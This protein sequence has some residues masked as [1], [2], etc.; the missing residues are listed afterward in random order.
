[1]HRNKL[2]EEENYYV[3]ERERMVTDQLI[4]RNIYDERLL[5]AMRTVPRHMFVPQEYRHSAYADGPLPIGNRQTISQPY[6]V[7]LMTQL[8]LLQGNERVLEVGTG[9]GYQAAIL[10]TLASEVHTIERHAA[11][12]QRA[13]EVL[14]GLNFANVHLH[15]GDGSGG[16]PEFAPYDAIIITA[17][18]PEVPRVILEQLNDSGR[19]VI[20]VGTWSGQSLERWR[21]QG[22]EYTSELLIP[23]AFVPLLGQYGWP[24]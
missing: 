15:V 16:L 13:G 17:A 9:S 12:S 5:E 3:T 11:L 19:L 8:L 7:A 23:V 6:I 14:T 10:G 1:M 20:P 22:S 21:R 24:S 4:C 2:V 18:A